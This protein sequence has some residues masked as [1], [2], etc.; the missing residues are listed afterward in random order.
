MCV[1]EIG[2]AALEISHSKVSFP[3][4]SPKIRTSANVSIKVE[5]YGIH[6]MISDLFIIL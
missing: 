3:W 2:E 4:K 6:D 1:T 5:N